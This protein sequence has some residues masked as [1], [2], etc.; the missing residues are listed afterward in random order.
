KGFQAVGAAADATL[1][2]ISNGLKTLGFDNASESVAN[3]RKEMGDAAQMAEMLAD[4]EAKYAESQRQANRIMLDYQRQAERLRQ[5]RDDESLS[6]SEREKANEQLG[7][8]LQEQLATEKQIAIQALEIANI[9]IAADGDTAANLDAQ[10]EAME[11]ICD[12]QERVE[13]QMSEQLTNRNQL[14]RDA[15]TQAKEAAA[16]AQRIAQERVAAMNEEI[17]LYIVQQGTRART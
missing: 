11:R 12:I 1:K 15:A 3:F 6:I 8:V 13:G 17:D 14:Q 7:K 10:A 2:F 5:V 16:E 4:R 9:S